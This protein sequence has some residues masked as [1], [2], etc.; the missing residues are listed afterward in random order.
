MKLSNWKATLFITGVAMTMS[1]CGDTSQTAN[2]A[3]FKAA[4]N[5]HFAKMKECYG[6]GNRADDQG[7]IQIFH[8]EG[9]DWTAKKREQFEYLEGLEVLEAVPFQKSEDS[10][11]K[12]G[13][14]NVVDYV[15]YKFSV[16]GSEY[17]RP[18]EYDSGTVEAGVPQLCYGTNQVV[19]VLNFTDPVAIGGVKASNVKFTYKLMDIAPWVES[20]SLLAELDKVTEGNEDLIL[21][22][23]GWMHH[24]EVK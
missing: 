16:M 14:T 17:V 6:V 23:S 21:T 20:P 1:A 7:F 18:E 5:A 19:D 15:G 11:L 22:D 12:P 8:A 9:R 10:V 3:N 2:K 24:L 13:T 4:L